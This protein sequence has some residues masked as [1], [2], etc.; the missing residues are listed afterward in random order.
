M[1]CSGEIMVKG[2]EQLSVRTL[3]LAARSLSGAAKISDITGSS[4]LGL[5]RSGNGWTHEPRQPGRRVAR[6]YPVKFRHRPRIVLV[7]EGCTNRPFF[8]IQIKSNLSETKAQGIE[9]VGSWDPFPNKIHGEELIALNLDR[10]F[11]WLARNAEPSTRVA[12]L[13]GLAGVF[14][15]H[16]RSYLVAHRARIATAAFIEQKKHDAASPT[17]ADAAASKADVTEVEQD[18]DTKT[19]ELDPK[20][21][22]DSVWRRGREP[23]WWWFN[24]LM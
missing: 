21:R 3:S 4:L 8:T 15:V 1:Q 13:L 12:E 11:Y 14:P 20:D 18:F 10:I 17:V 22:P 7:R 19:T 24:G 5:G 2:I 6:M 16:P 23:P 9:Q